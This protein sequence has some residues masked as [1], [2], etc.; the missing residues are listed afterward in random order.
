MAKVFVARIFPAMAMAGATF[1]TL[2][3]PALAQSDELDSGFYFTARAGVASPSDFNLEG[4]Q[5]PED[6]SP[7]TAGAPAN[8]DVGFDNAST[9]AGAIGYKVPRK[10]FGLVQPSIE[11]EYAYTR[12]EVS[13]GSFNG[14]N[15]TFLGDVEVQTI[16]L[17]Y[18]S[19]FILS[20]NQ[21]V[22]P[23]LGG[24]IGIADVDANIRYFPASATSPTFGVV[25]SDTGLILQS[26]AGLRFDLSDR[27]AID[28]RVRY[29]RI[30]EL[31]FDRRFIANGNDAFN[32]RVSDQYESVNFLAGVRYSF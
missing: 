2:S 13:S 25:S 12:P 24:G 18:Q 22:T 7:G 5:A 14:G 11:I 26:N 9:F 30:T 15:Q 27:I 4:V 1:A 28:G 21:R 6:P 19:D 31:D 16:T 20:E 8:V 3:T 17:N 32:A 23:F 29:Q 10:V